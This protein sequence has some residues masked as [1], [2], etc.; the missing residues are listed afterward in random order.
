MSQSYEAEY[1]RLRAAAAERKPQTA[2][3][4]A[5]ELY[6][7]ARRDGARDHMLR[8]LAYRATYVQETN[9]DGADAAAAL[10]RQQLTAAADDPTVAAVL[11]L[12]LGQVYYRYGQNNSWRLRNNT[13]VVGDSTATDTPL[14]DLTLA[15]LADRASEHLFS[16]L[17]LARSA[18]TPLSAIPAIVTHDSARVAERPTLFDLVALEAL[19]LLGSP[20]LTVTDES[21]AQPAQYLGS[22][23]AF[24]AAALPDKDNGPYRKLA[25]YQ[26]LTNYHLGPPTPALLAV[27]R[28]RID[29]VRSLGVSDTAYAAALERLHATYATTPGGDIWLVRR[30]QALLDQ[31]EADTGEPPVGAEPKTFPYADALALLN[32]VADTTAFVRYEAEA[33]RRR[34]LEQSLNVSVAEVN[35]VGENILL[36]LRFRNLTT[37]HQRL[38]ALADGADVPERGY[39]NDREALAELLRG[40]PLRRRTTRLPATDDYAAHTTEIG[41]D[42]LPAGR[43]CLVTSTDA[44]FDPAGGIMGVNDFQVSSLA[45]LRHE[46]P[47]ELAFTVTDRVSGLPRPGA[48]VDIQRRTY[49]PRGYTS[50]RKLTVGDDG[51]F[52]VRDG[53]VMKL[54]GQRRR[55]AFRFVVTDPARQDRLVTQETGVYPYDR[56]EPDAFSYTALFTDRQL[57]RPGQTVRVY[58]LTLHRD[59]DEMPSVR[60][61][62]AREL[63]LRD[64]N[65]QEVGRAEVTSDDYGR[66]STAFRL[67]EGGLTGVFRLSSERGEV[68]FRV[69]EYK[70]PRFAV[71]LEVPDFAVA[72]ERTP[73]TGRA[74]L[75]AGP[76]VDGARVSYRVFRE[77]VTYWWW[78]DAGGTDRFLVADG[79]TTTDATG[80]FT[81]D[82]LAPPV[83]GTGRER[84]RYLIEADVADAS[85]ETQAGSASVSQRAAKPTVALRAAADLFPLADSLRILAAGPAETVTLRYTIAPVTKP[86]TSVRARMWSFPDRPLLGPKDY[87]ARFPDYATEVTPEPARWP[88]AGP[89]ARRGELTVADGEAQLDL[90]VADL[91]VGHYRVDWTYPDGTAGEPFTFALVDTERALLPAGVDHYLHAPDGP[92]RVGEPLRVDLIVPRPTYVHAVWGSRRGLRARRDRAANRITYE[93]TPTEADRGGLTLRG[94]YLRHNEPQTFERSFDVAWDNKELRVRYDVFRDALRP[95]APERW[96]LTVTNADGSP[97]PAAALATMYDASLDQIYAGQPWRFRPFPGYQSYFRAVELLTHGVDYG[98]GRAAANPARLPTVPRLPR[99]DLD[100]FTGGAP[101]PAVY[102]TAGQMRMRQS[103]RTD[104]A[105]GA[106]PPPPAPAVMEVAEEEA[107]F[108]DADAAAGVTANKTAAPEAA[109][110]A[111]PVQIRTNLQETAFWLPELSANDD[112]Q[113]IVSFTSP[114]ALTRWKFRLFAHDRELATVISERTVTTRKELMV[115]PNVPRFVRGGDRIDLAARV[116]NLSEDDLDARVTLELFDPVTNA[117]LPAEL[118]QEMGADAGAGAVAKQGRLPAGGGETFRFTLTVPERLTA[119]GALGYRIIAR[120]GEFS[121]GEQN[122]FPVLTDRTLVTVSQPFYLKRGQTKT[123]T[124]P[125]LAG[126]DSPTLRH[127]SYTLEGTTNPAWLALKSLPYL[128]EYPYDCTEQL[129][130][131]YFANQLAYATVSAKPVLEQV[132]RAWQADSTALQSELEANPTLKNALLTETPWVRAAADEAAQRARIGTLFDLKRLADEQ[133][134][135][136]NKLLRRQEDSGYFSWFPGGPPNRYMTQYVL[137]TLGRMRQLGVVPPGQEQRLADLTGRAIA[138]LDRS[139]RAD[140]EQLVARMDQAGDAGW[141]DGYRPSSSVVHYLYARQLAQA[142]QSQQGDAKWLTEGAYRFYTERAYASWTDYGLYEQALLAAA[143]AVSRA[144]WEAANPRDNSYGRPTPPR[145]N[146]KAYGAYAKLIVE[147]LRERALHD[148]ERGMFWKYGRGFSWNQLPLETH[149]RLLEAFRTTGAPAE[150][151]DALRLWLLTNKRTNRWPTT[152]A[153]A[154]AV[155]ALMN[156]GTDWTT[157]PAQPLEAKW[158]SLAS[159]KTLA[160]RV[161]AQQETA[162]AATG[163]FRLTLTAEEVTD[164][165]AKVRLSN[166]GNELVWGGVYWQY[167]EVA[168]RVGAADNGPLSLERALYRRVVTDEGVRLEPVTD[169]TPLESGDRV[170]VKLTLRS[171]RALDY[172]HLRDR[173]AATFEPRQQT[174]GYRSGGGLGYYF[175]PGDLA[176]NFFIDHLPRGTYVLEYDLFATH[177]GSFSNGLGRV[178]CMYAPEF[179]GNTAGGRTVVR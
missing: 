154:A 151:L 33:L 113:L 100:P 173:R 124:V 28:A 139:Y 25:V 29:F 30:A 108:M 128:M 165:L 117:A 179:G 121:D 42:K 114:E 92:L 136:L 155:Y 127:V 163:A 48:G 15:A 105:A 23:A 89:V 174:S 5:E 56:R 176:T 138:Y 68:A 91:S 84:Y 131:R 129:A 142:G 162:E 164:G 97:L 79:E 159:G 81:F 88:T 14:G 7:A 144:R 157:Q 60:T 160:S 18:R 178:Q 19:D 38:Y 132:F 152:K 39:R 46:T 103:A 77:K 156:T 98:R 1:A 70:R 57:Y 64:A 87:A 13:P 27:D 75:F 122:A 109:E 71:E 58:G 16:S 167:T 106:P 61:R 90:A 69:E 47:A 135:A 31:M 40:K 82:F 50:V 143:D 102:A 36:H 99:L 119:R 171:D 118:R 145:V 111:A 93:Y 85:G 101:R 175:A 4:A 51:R 112:G 62:R 2:L 63:T 94:G 53:A 107:L 73:V 83:S 86:G 115:L 12:M 130:N 43:Y 169:A 95:G 146:D 141:R 49:D 20:L 104:D 9:E 3:A 140:Y 41:L 125:G 37:V 10:L 166:P 22:A 32:R 76:G 116:N 149:C 133:S 120:A 148:D 24:A 158:P 6:A 8:A 123:V 147:S 55:G 67:P 168:A 26:Q 80:E 170:T 78:R 134:A 161:R 59:P 177:A 21:V 34:I 126:A 17:R 54:L 35:P 110:P 172:V 137:E 65:Y 74:R 52:V 150:E 66:F 44:D 72:G 45:V 153:T 96:M 11:H